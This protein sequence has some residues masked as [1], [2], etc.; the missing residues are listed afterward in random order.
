M[1]R[2]VLYIFMLTALVA[3]LLASPVKAAP[4][5]SYQSGFQIRNLTS[6]TATITISFY[7]PDGTVALAVDDEV[8][9][10]ATNTYFPL[11][12]SHLKGGTLPSGFKGS[13]VIASDTPVASMSN[14][15]GYDSANAPISYASFSASF[16]GANTLSLP[17]LMK[18]NYGYN[19]FFAIQ[20]TGTGPTD[21]T[22]TYSDGTVVTKTAVPASASATFEQASETHTAS[23]FSASVTSGEPVAATVVEVGPNTL[24]SYSGFTAGATNP[25]MPLVNENNYGY[26]TGVQIQNLG[27]SDTDVT[28]SYSPG[29]AGTACLETRTVPA[30]K[31]ATFAQGVFTASDPNGSAPKANT[32]TLGQ[33]FVGAGKVTANTASMPLVAVVNQLNPATTAPKGAAYM[34]FNP[35]DGKAKIVYPL[36]MDRNFGYFTSWSIANVSETETVAKADLVCTVTGTDISGAAVTKTFSPDADIVPGASWTLNH[37]NVIANRFVGGATCVSAD[38]NDKLVGSANQLATGPIDSFLV[39]EGFAVD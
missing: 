10:D 31:S 9:G 16:A 6:G 23:V 18:A 25:M 15:V 34:G 2:K 38:A 21:I 1:L 13:V 28:V 8:P 26:F 36:I 14:L 4:P 24:F 29:L 11:D 12:S 27:A 39:Y 37:I 17:L 35:A 33:Q 5:V 20:N 19:T 22:V 3:G 30:G 7:N 32:C